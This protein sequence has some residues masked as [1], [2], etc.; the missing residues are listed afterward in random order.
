MSFISPIFEIAVFLFCAIYMNFF[1]FILA[2]FACL[3]S[4]CQIP[5]FDRRY[6]FKVMTYALFNIVCWLISIS[7]LLISSS[8]MIP[9]FK[10]DMSLG[11]SRVKRNLGGNIPY[12]YSTTL[13]CMIIDTSSSQNTDILFAMLVMFFA[14]ISGFILYHLALGSL[15]ETHFKKSIAEIS[16]LPPQTTFKQVGSYE[17]DDMGESYYI[18]YFVKKIFPIFKLKSKGCLDRQGNFTVDYIK[19]IPYLDVKALVKMIKVYNKW[20][21]NIDTE[22]ISLS[23]RLIKAGLEFLVETLQDIFTISNIVYASL[24]GYIAFFFYFKNQNPSLFSFLP[25]IGI[26]LLGIREFKTFIF[27]SQFLIGV[28]LIINFMLFYFSNLELDIAKCKGSTM[29]YCQPWFGYIRKI[30]NPAI[31]SNT[32]LKETLVKI[33][34]FQGIF[35]FYRMLKFSDELFVEKSSEEMNLDIEESFNRGNLPFIRIVIIQ[36]FSK[37]YVVCLMLMLYIGTSKV[38]YTNMVLLIIAVTYMTKTKLI[39]KKW[40]FIYVIMNLIF[41]SAYFIDLIIN[42]SQGVAKFLDKSILELIGL[43]VT[44]TDGSLLGDNVSEVGN[45]VLVMVLYI[46]CLVQ[47][48]AGKNKY[49]KCYLV[50]LNQIKNQKD[51]TYNLISSVNNWKQKFKIYTVKVYYKAGVWLGYGLNIYLPLFQSISFMRVILLIVIVATFIIH[52][53][54]LRVATVSGKVYLDKTYIMWKV[55]LVLKVINISMLIAGVFGVNKLLRTKL[56]I[57]KD[58]SD[59]LTINYIGVESMELEIIAGVT[60]LQNC[61]SNVFIQANRLRFYFFIETITFIFT[62][63]A[64]KIIQIQRIY[65]NVLSDYVDSEETYLMIKEEKPKLYRIYKLYHKYII[66]EGFVKSKSTNKLFSNIS[67]FL[68]RIYTSLIYVI[69]LSIS[70]FSNISLL[71]FVSLFFFLNYFIKMNSIF[72][73]Y[74]TKANVERVLDI[75][76]LCL[77]QN[78]SSSMRN[79]SVRRL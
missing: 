45:R 35:F 54:T 75:S 17:E 47:Q 53:N 26:F 64:M 50:K 37:F 62:K 4:F 2:F 66:G 10:N 19:T 24:F 3:V 49:I 40:I 38:S 6:S 14:F 16:E 23:R 59:Y 51:D 30:G 73:D 76:M 71:M 79:I 1:G 8:N 78:L 46:C 58:S 18:N 12:K 11:N 41:I 27:Y 22:D 63:I 20:K 77:N 68:A 21:K 60:T 5:S 44:F 61:M 65:N 7:A 13:N 72:L 29:F 43:P 32:V 33:F 42:S 25:F 74:L 67:S 34:L 69:T 70:I 31:S 57:V 9:Y 52:I 55:F 48:I 56:D 15:S 39:K 28:P 36:I